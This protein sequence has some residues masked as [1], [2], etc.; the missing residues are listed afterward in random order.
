MFTFKLTKALHLTSIPLAIAYVVYYG[1]YI[2]Y[3][4]PYLIG[5][6]ILLWLLTQVFAIGYAIYLVKQL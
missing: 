6:N 3:V 2:W 1:Y 5:F 4:L